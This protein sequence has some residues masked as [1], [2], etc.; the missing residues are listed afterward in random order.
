LKD[1]FT[2]HRENSPTSMSIQLEFTH[3]LDSQETIDWGYAFFFPFLN[4]NLQLVSQKLYTITILYNIVRL[5]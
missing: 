2:Q 3:K 4:N 1:L 5:V